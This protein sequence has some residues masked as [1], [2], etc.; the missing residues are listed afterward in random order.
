MELHKAIKDIVVQKGAEMINNIQII[1]YLLDYQAFKDKP[2]TKLIL[3]DVI[4]AGYGESILALQNTQGWQTKF[5]QYEHEFID[6]CGYKEELA[7]YVFESIAYALGLNKNGNEEPAIKPS[8][9]VDS[10]FDIP[11][12]E[13]QQPSNAP[14]D[15]NKQSADPTDLYT[16]ALSFYNEE[17]YQQ[18]KGFI[19]KAINTQPNV[20]IPSHHL[21]LLGDIY[22]RLGDYENAIKCYNECFTQKAKEERCTIDQL[23]ESFKQHKV[24]D[25]KNIMF[26]YFFCL[27][28]AKRMNDVQWLQFVKGEARYG[29]MD[30]IK[31][32]ADNRINPM[33][34]HIDIYFTDKN[35]IKDGDYLYKD[36]TFSHE[37]STSKDLIARVYLMKT[38]EYERSQGWTHGYIIPF[39]NAKSNVTP[40]PYSNAVPITYISLMEDQLYEWSQ[41]C[42]DL[43]FPHSHYSID[44]LKH[45]NEIDKIESEHFITIP[46]SDCQKYPAFNAV[47]QYQIKMPLS[48]ASNWFIPSVIHVKRFA[49]R[50]IYGQYFG[51]SHCYW[52]S[53]QSDANNAISFTCWYDSKGYKK[54]KKDNFSC[55]N[56]T[57]KLLV[58]PIAVF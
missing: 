51:G 16:I 31:Y 12:V 4:N 25:Y 58:L 29:L 37:S 46:D 13:V 53:S 2:A 23:R 33:E 34:S 6:S 56:K 28:A 54:G 35:Q 21:R 22:M 43:P 27:Y 39:E 44:D 26:C 5:K 45:W 38:T 36:G 20:S 48:Y 10:F 49:L 11:E 7:A 32:C 41:K 9:N 8:F 57:E 24:K 47:K 55:V 50:C 15:S 14:Q 52:T 17:K 19:E 30:A 42:E 18:A 3:C 40:A 1:N